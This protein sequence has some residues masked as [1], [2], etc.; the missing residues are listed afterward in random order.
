MLKRLAR[1][2]VRHIKTWVREGSDADDPTWL[3]ESD[4]VSDHLN[5][6][7]LVECVVRDDY[8]FAT[9]LVSGPYARHRARLNP[10]HGQR[11]SR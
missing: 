4:F 8:D 3:L 5:Y 1:W 2:G 7:L 9:G 10:S 6:R 11:I